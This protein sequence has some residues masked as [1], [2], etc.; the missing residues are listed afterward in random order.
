LLLD[1]FENCL[2]AL[3]PG[4]QYQLLIPNQQQP[5]RPGTWSHALLVKLGDADRDMN[6]HQLAAVVLRNNDA[7]FG[8]AALTLETAKRQLAA[9]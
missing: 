8:K 1:G 4:F 9:L 3:L 2:D 7:A 5:Q 6:G